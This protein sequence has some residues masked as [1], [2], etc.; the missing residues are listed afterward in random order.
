M[1]SPRPSAH[2]RRG[3]YDRAGASSAVVQGVVDHASRALPA[4]A[5]PVWLV[6]RSLAYVSGVTHG[7]IGFE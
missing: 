3:A 5:P 6:L 2:R 7:Y 4:T 1:R